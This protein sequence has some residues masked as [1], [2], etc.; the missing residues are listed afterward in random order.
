MVKGLRMRLCCEEFDRHIRN[1]KSNIIYDEKYHLY[2]IL[3]NTP[4]STQIIYH[5]PW[6]GSHLDR[7]L[8]DEWYG[9][10]SSLGYNFN[11][12]ETWDM[13]PEVY[14]TDE[15]WKNDEIAKR[16]RYR[17]KA[18]LY[19]ITD[20]ENDN[21]KFIKKNDSFQFPCCERIRISVSDDKLPYIFEPHLNR[22]GIINQKG[23]FQSTSYCCWCGHSLL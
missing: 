10:L 15:W 14:F 1:S 8:T 17:Y 9:R 4:T 11:L 3:Y 18:S 6:C 19:S 12:P 5:C 2:G 7:D 22:Y 16:I 13:I 23:V 20:E 21:I